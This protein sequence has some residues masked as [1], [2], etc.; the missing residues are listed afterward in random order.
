[1]GT[2]LKAH[3][4]LK[5]NIDAILQAR[6]LKRKDLAQWCH[7]TESWLSQIFIDDERNVPL[8][9]LDR[10][11]DF[12]GLAT[13]QLF[14]PGIGG[15]SERR[16]GGDRRSGQDR[17]ISRHTMTPTVASLVSEIQ[18]LQPKDVPHVRKYVAWLRRSEG[19]EPGTAPPAVPPKGAGPRAVPIQRN[20]AEPLP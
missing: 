15:A 9:Y 18:S 17:R 16:K 5:R 4:L 11:A 7:R 3:I 2:A 19:A 8:K 14:Q 20:R 12:F 6:G 13:Y 10:I 1:M